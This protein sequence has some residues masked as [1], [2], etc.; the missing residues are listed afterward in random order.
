[1]CP[2][3]SAMD[4]P[5][6]Q[7]AQVRSLGGPQEKG[8]AAHSDILAWRILCT[9]EP[10]RLQSMGSQRV[11]HDYETNTMKEIKMVKTCGKEVEVFV[12]IY[13]IKMRKLACRCMV[14]NKNI[15]SFSQV[16]RSLGGSADLADPSLSPSRLGVLL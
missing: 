12:K 13:L 16:C 11:R 6:V 14:Y 7:E 4:L 9:E 15:F 10:G 2:Y 8:M 1:M 5:A 3:V